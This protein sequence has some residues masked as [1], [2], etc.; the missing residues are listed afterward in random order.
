MHKSDPE[1]YLHRNVDDWLKRA[2][3]GAI[4]L[5]TFQRSYVWDNDRTA[6]Y[7]RA[8]FQ[9]R[10]TGTFL[11]LKADSGSNLPFNARNLKGL[12][13]DTGRTEELLLDGQQRLTSLWNALG[14]DRAGEERE[15]RFFVR[16]ENL[17]NLRMAVKDVVFFSKSS[18]NG[19]ERNE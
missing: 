4:A 3:D 13:A 8:L 11:V 5:P 12:D 15:H 16:V 7:L 9:D 17:S 1:R 18:K 2:S 14:G 19:R 10:P 6:Q